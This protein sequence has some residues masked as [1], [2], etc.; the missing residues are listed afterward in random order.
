MAKAHARDAA[1]IRHSAQTRALFQKYFFCAAPPCSAQERSEKEKKN[2][3]APTVRTRCNREYS[4]KRKE[5]A[6]QVK[7]TAHNLSLT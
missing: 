7:A 5:D 4:E 3:R 6:M 1:R 2:E